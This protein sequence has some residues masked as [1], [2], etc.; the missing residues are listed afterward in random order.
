MFGRRRKPLALCITACWRVGL[1]SESRLIHREVLSGLEGK[2][3][4]PAAEKWQGA[5]VLPYKLVDLSWRG[6][7]SLSGWVYGCFVS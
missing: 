6:V 4:K 5:G 1:L 7:I 3:C 2:P